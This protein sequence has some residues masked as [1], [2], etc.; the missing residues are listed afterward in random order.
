MYACIHV[1]TH[2]VHVHIY[3][4]MCVNLL[5]SVYS[6]VVWL[7][8]S[9]G[10]PCLYNVCNC[11]AALTLNKSYRVLL[12]DYCLAASIF[13]RIIKCSSIVIMSN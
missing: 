1:C 11:K 6:V 10:D 2:Y 7:H 4:P 9:L 3:R 13:P 8:A 5:V 12:K